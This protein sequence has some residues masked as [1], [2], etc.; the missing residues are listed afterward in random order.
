MFVA[1][2]DD[3]DGDEYA[4]VNTVVGEG[5]ERTI[6]LRRDDCRVNSFS[7]NRKEIVLVFIFSTRCFRS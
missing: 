1:T 5:F 7:L 2:E 6:S 4:E 3:D